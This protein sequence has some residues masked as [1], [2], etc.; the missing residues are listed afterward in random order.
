[1]SQTRSVSSS[2][3]RYLSLRGRKYEP[4]WRK[5]YLSYLQLQSWTPEGADIFQEAHV[6]PLS[7]GYWVFLSSVTFNINAIYWKVIE[8]HTEIYLLYVVV[9]FYLTVNF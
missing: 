1:M 5:F 3:F 6:Y 4:T 8:K 2:V 9:F 7:P